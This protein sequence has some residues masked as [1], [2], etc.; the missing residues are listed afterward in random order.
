MVEKTTTLQG[1]RNKNKNREN[2]QRLGSG[3][4]GQHPC[5]PENRRKWRKGPV[6]HELYVD[7]S[8]DSRVQWLDETRQMLYVL[9]TWEDI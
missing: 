9:S 4:F 2:K 5:P 6:Q 8:R 1:V 7:V 3:E